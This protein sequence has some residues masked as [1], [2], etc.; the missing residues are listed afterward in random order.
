LRRGLR[1][2]G[3]IRDVLG[4]F[5]VKGLLRASARGRQGLE[6]R[7][8]EEPGRHARSAF[9]LRRLSPS[10]E[11]DLARNVFGGCFVAGEAKGK[12]I[13]PTVMPGEQDLHGKPVA[14][15]H[16]PQQFLIGRRLRH[17]DAPPRC[18]AA[19]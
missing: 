5:I 4:I 17:A 14:I 6:A 3:V 2:V 11:E 9:E 19:A 12:A 7:H 18:V 10:L 15:S 1:I 13:D 16:P 8:A